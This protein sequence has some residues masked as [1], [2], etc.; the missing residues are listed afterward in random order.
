MIY[1]HST[2]GWMLIHEYDIV[3]AVKIAS[4]SLAS[5]DITID[6]NDQVS[7]GLRSHYK[8]LV[9]VMY[10]IVRIGLL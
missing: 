10:S 6:D 7:C 9:Q 4:K 2:K 1:T 5:I 3:I 8:S